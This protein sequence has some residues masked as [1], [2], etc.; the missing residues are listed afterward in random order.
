MTEAERRPLK[1]KPTTKRGR[2]LLKLLEAGKS[3]RY[4]LL[5]EKQFK[6]EMRE[7]VG[8]NF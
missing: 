1:W 6:R 7:R 3:E 2:V 5:N 4:P 8:R